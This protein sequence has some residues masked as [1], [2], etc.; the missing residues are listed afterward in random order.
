M[1]RK[2]LASLLSLA[3][4][5][6][7][8]PATAFGEDFSSVMKVAHASSKIKNCFYGLAVHSERFNNA[9]GSDMLS[10][11]IYDDA[12]VTVTIKPG[13][14]EPVHFT[15]FGAEID[16]LSDSYLISSNPNSPSMLYLFKKGGDN[17]KNRLV[18][19]SG[20]HSSGVKFDCALSDA[21]IEAMIDY[22]YS[23]G[24]GSN[25]SYLDGTAFI[26]KNDTA[27]SL[28][29]WGWRNNEEYY[30]LI[31]DLPI[32][33]DDEIVFSHGYNQKITVISK[34]ADGS[35]YQIF[36]YENGSWAQKATISCSDIEINPDCVAGYKNKIFFYGDNS[37][38]ENNT[39][40]FDLIREQWTALD[41]NMPESS[42]NSIACKDDVL[43]LTQVEGDITHV[44]KMPVPAELQGDIDR[45]SAVTASDAALILQ[46]VLDNE[47]TALD[48]EQL[49]LGALSGNQEIIAADAAQILNIALNN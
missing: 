22:G 39:C 16:L 28:Y 48:R 18:I 36:T 9:Y 37:F 49:E 6:S 42:T 10:V 17:P 20:S 4:V 23:S 3:L 14:G 13:Y 31:A 12:D 1:K 5:S 7:L 32:S 33:V 35:A 45:N 43:Y 34:L 41:G 26:V 24:F 27:Y 25:S 8:L 29:D 44:Y 19:T 38:S 2:F 40:M 21:A 15:T 47:G 46:Y 11:Q 30:D